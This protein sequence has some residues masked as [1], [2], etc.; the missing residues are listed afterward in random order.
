[1]LLSWRL[2]FGFIGGLCHPTF[3]VEELITQQPEHL[4]GHLWYQQAGNNEGNVVMATDKANIW[5]C[6]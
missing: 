4:S 6:L 1:L 2:I 5:N 3:S